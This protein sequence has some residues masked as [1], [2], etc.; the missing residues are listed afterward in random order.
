MMLLRFAHQLEESRG[1]TTDLVDIVISTY[2]ETQATPIPESYRGMAFVELLRHRLASVSTGLPTGKRESV[3]E[4]ETAN[5]TA[6]LGLGT[7]ANVGERLELTGPQLEELYA[8]DGAELDLVVSPARL[9][10]SVAAATRDIA[11]LVAAGRQARGEEWTPGAAIRAV[12]ADYR[13]YDEANVARAV[14]DM[15]EEFRF[16]GRGRSREMRLTRPGWDRARAL[17]RRLTAEV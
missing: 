3:E 2:E 15:E 17:A 4:S 7:L 1:N 5:P 14:G 6:G 9:P 16:R 12:C 11:L 10:S 8:L 13:R